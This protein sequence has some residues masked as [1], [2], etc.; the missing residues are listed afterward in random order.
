M[1]FSLMNNRWKII[2]RE[3]FYVNTVEEARLTRAI[4]RHFHFPVHTHHPC[5]LHFALKTNVC[6]CWS[7][8]TARLNRETRLRMRSTRAD[9]CHE[10]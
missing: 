1:K 3:N 4:A 5:T 6:G 8:S 9:A 7:R 10:S 2:E